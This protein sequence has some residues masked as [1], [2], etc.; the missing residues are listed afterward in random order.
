MTRGIV[1]GYFELLR[2]MRRPGTVRFDVEVAEALR[3]SSRRGEG[4]LLLGGHFG[5][6][7]LVGNL[8]P[9]RTGIP[10]STIGKVPHS[11]GAADLI[12]RAREAFGLGSIPP[13]E[14]AMRRVMR[15]LAEGQLVV[16]T[17][18]QNH[19]GGLP[20]PFFGR[21][22]L[23]ATAL[24]AVAAR[25]RVPVYFCEHWREGTGHHRA[26]ISGPLPTTGRVEDDT[27]AFTRR[28]EDAIRRRPHNWLW[29]HNR[30]KGVP[31]RG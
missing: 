15:L 17:L 21:P 1:L 18:D 13:D 16:F 12:A 28:V 29:L 5:S 3:E 24:A 11:R 7:D 26:L 4:A 10:M 19:P 22:A 30:W 8:L 27:V 2:E 20:V 9:G 14:R 6:W 25:R 23:A 31:A